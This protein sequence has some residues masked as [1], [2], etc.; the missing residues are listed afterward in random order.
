MV[1]GENQINLIFDVV[2]PTGFTES[3]KKL[4]E[5]IDIAC[6]SIDSRYQTVVTIDR[7]YLTNT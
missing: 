5:K 2:I 1:D 3:D 6:K 7:D 4:R